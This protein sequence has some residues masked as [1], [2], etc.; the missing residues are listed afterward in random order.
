MMTAG[1]IA[2]AAKALFKPIQALKSEMEIAKIISK[3]PKMIQYITK[4]K[5]VLGSVGGKVGE[6]VK[7]L[8]TK[9]P[10]LSKWVGGLTSGVSKAI[11]W[12]GSMLGKVLTAP[13]KVAA[14]VGDTIQ[15]AKGIKDIKYLQNKTVG[16][17]LKSA[18]NGAL[19]MGGIEGG[20]HLRQ[21]AEQEKINTLLN[22]KADYSNI[23]F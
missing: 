5:N 15:S 8:S 4:L 9:A 14:K 21:G 22:A 10:K 17:G 13:G 7:Y 1:P 23:Q 3:S 16:S 20:V 19:V 18:T 11:N 2:K 6:L 12:I